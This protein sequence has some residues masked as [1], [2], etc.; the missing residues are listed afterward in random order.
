VYLTGPYAGAPLG[1]Q[2]LIPAAGGPFDLGSVLVRSRILV[3]PKTLAL[4]IA[5]DPLPQS[6]GGISLRLRAVDVTLDRPAFIVN[7]TSC[8]PQS[9]TAT[10][11][12]SEGAAASLSTPFRVAGCTDLPFTPHVS[13][14]TQAGA[15][16]EGNGASL[17]FKVVS[18]PGAQATFSGVTAELPGQLR[19][20]LR[21]LQAACR[22]GSQV[23]S[24][25]ACPTMSAIGRAVVSSPAVPASLSGS[26]YL[27]EHSGSALPSMAMVLEGDGLE[28]ELEGALSL[29]RKGAPIVTFKRLPDVRI[30]S[31]AVTLPRGPRSILG[32]IANPCD[33]RLYLGYSL[34]DHA[35]IEEKGRARIAVPGC[36]LRGKA[37]NRA[38][39]TQHAR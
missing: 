9:I 8:V 24:L 21:T 30:S 23:T 3:N 1:L 14:S 36:P 13:A 4:T 20:R 22:L 28:V 37:R 2:I 39:R 35:G 16:A 7:P 31:L 18:P 29:S 11:T 5:S 26:I 10:I 25:Q 32:A 17:S 12:S 15:S 38:G 6:L 34:A 27:V 33:E 19:P